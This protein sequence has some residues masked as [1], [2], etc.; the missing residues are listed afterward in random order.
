MGKEQKKSIIELM[1]EKVRSDSAQAKITNVDAFKEEPIKLPE[2]DLED[3]LEVFKTEEE[4]ADIKILRG[5]GIYLFS[6]DKMTLNYA[7]TMARIA[8]KDIMALI[9]STVRDDSE[10][11]P[12]ATP[13]KTFYQHP[14]N[15]DKGIFDD[16]LEEMENKEEYKDIKGVRA[17]NG[18][19]YLYSNKYLA[20][21]HAAYLAED[22]EVV[23]KEV[24]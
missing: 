9:A 12:R 23:Q 7:K 2:E 19:L 3:K 8:D 21:D 11:Y 17:S 18:A 24:P 5:T 14:Y 6:E 10:I 1:A 4:Y 15:I 22:I 20:E 16:V 13:A